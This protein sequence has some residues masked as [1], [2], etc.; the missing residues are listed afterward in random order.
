MLRYRRALLNFA[1]IEDSK[2]ISNPIFDHESNKEDE[3]MHN[4]LTANIKCAIMYR[5]E[6]S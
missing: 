5:P 3:V 4:I 1:Y 2:I 6:Q